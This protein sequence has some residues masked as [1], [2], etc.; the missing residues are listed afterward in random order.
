MELRHRVLRQMARTVARQALDEITRDP[1]RGL[2]SLV[3]FVAY[4]AS[5]PAQQEALGRLQD[6]LSPNSC[7]Y[8]LAKRMVAQVDHRRLEALAQAVITNLGYGPELLRQE[9]RR[10]GLRLP[11]CISLD[12]PVPGGSPLFQEAQGLGCH[13]FLLQNQTVRDICAAALRIPEAFFAAALRARQLG[14]EAVRQLQQAP[15]LAVSVEISP[16]EIPRET[17]RRLQEGGCLFGAHLQ[18]DGRVDLSQ[19]RSLQER[20]AK[21]GCCFLS[22]LPGP[23]ADQF[24]G[25]QNLLRDRERGK[26]S[27]L[28]LL[29]AQD[30]A[31]FAGVLS[32]GV[33]LLRAYPEAPLLSQLKSKAFRER[34]AAV[35]KP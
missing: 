16:G 17:L 3:D 29:P 1:Q 15:N 10:T 32:P 34:R 25:A 19:E 20:L 18:R 14:P 30:L 6:A 23:R 5:T 31:W 9:S 13:L 33:P 26:S 2:R 24:Q 27:L 21:A 22:Y 4:C 12:R 7:Y 8:Q 35:Q 28:L 11:W